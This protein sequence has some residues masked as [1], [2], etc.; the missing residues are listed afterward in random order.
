MMI[1]ARK[2][3]STL[4][5]KKKCF[6]ETARRKAKIASVEFHLS[7]AGMKQSFCFSFSI[8]LHAFLLAYILLWELEKPL[9]IVLRLLQT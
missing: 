2:G 1:E 6:F 4:T 5:K 8:N 3:T 7:R 9:I